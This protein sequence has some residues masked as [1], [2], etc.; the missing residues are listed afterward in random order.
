MTTKVNTEI[1]PSGARWDDKAAHGVSLCKSTETG[2]VPAPGTKT[3]SD[4][5]GKSRLARRPSPR[6]CR[7]SPGPPGRAGQAAPGQPRDLSQREPSTPRKLP[8]PLYRFGTACRFRAGG[9]SGRDAGAAALTA[10]SED[11]A[12]P[13]RSEGT[14]GCRAGHP[15]RGDAGI[16][17]PLFHVARPPKMRATR[18]GWRRHK[19]GAPGQWGR[20][21]PRGTATATPG[22]SCP[23]AGRPPRPTAPRPPGPR[24]ASPRP[25]RRPPRR[26]SSPIPR[27]AA[28]GGP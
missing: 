25:P 21:E 5:D 14:R 13:S 27:C 3:Q 10:P 18:P 11:Q 26:S 16:P 12:R 4:L 20:T 9:R 28:S 7:A 8:D 22:A 2:P 15:G 1:V 17:N 19:S 24:P 23:R 6:L